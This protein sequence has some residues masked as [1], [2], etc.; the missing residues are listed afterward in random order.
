NAF[1]GFPW[2]TLGAS[3]ASV[4]PIVQL[5]SVTGVHGLSALVSLVSAAAAALAFGRRR[6]TVMGTVAVGVLL[7]AVAPGGPV[8]L[9]ASSLTRTGTVTRVGLVQGN[10]SLLEKWDARSRD[11]ILS[12]YLSLS[13]QAIGAGASMVFWP[14]ASTPFYFDTEGVLAEPVRRLAFQA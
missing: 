11:V 3:Q 6:S 13:Q 12:R 9:A 5:A 7:V 8:R 2:G 4:L 1:G 10:V 14:E